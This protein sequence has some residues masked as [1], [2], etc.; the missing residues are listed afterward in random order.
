[1]LLGECLEDGGVH[2]F[3]KAAVDD[4][5]VYSIR[6]QDVRRFDRRMDHRPDSKDRHILPTAE[7]FPGAVWHCGDLPDR[8]KLVWCLV[9]G[10]ARAE[11]AI[12]AERSS[13]KTDQLIPVFRCGHSYSRN[14]EHVGDVI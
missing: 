2:R 3:H 8:I 9:P 14:R 6:R 13:E 5:A 4:R 11:W 7:L 1:M 12:V 10:V